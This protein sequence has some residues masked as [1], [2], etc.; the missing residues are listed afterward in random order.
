[1]DAVQLASI[2]L[3]KKTGRRVLAISDDQ[4][5][6]IGV[7]A[8]GSDSALTQASFTLI[9]AAALAEAVLAG[10]PTA[11]TQPGAERMLAAALIITLRQIG[12]D[13]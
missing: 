8:D 6:H 11:M 3:H 1:M 4:V 2:P 7:A 12:S 10:N 13:G 5:V 9:E